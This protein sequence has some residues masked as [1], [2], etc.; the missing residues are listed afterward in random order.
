VR[1]TFALVG[2][3]LLGCTACGSSSKNN[4]GNQSPFNFG[5]KPVASQAAT[6]TQPAAT[7]AGQPS[8]TQ[9]AQASAPSA[10]GVPSATKPSGAPAGGTTSGG[11]APAPGQPDACKLVTQAEAEAELGAT[12]GAGTRKDAGGDAECVYQSADQLTL[13]SVGLRKATAGISA[14]SVFQNERKLLGS[15]VQD[16]PGVGDGAFANK[17]LGTINVL[18]GSRELTIQ[19]VDLKLLGSDELVTKL[20]DLAKKAVGRM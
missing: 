10:P 18:K 6:Q 5:A 7:Q 1:A 20:T 17:S 14:R 11:N 19:I 12:L 16:V 8:A 3:L 13:V 9:A 4:S 15:T 2:L